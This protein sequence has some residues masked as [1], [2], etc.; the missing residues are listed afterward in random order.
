MRLYESSLDF[1]RVLQ[2]NSYAVQRGSEQV[3]HDLYQPIL[4]RIRAIRADHPLRDYYL[5]AYRQFLEE[6][7]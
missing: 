1:R 7:R 3:L 4:N 6:A 5:S 2:T